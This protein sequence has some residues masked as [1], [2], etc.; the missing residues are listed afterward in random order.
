MANNKP[1]LDEISFFH[2][3][4]IIWFEKLKIFIITIFSIGLAVGFIFYKNESFEVRTSIKPSQQSVFVKFTSLNQILIDNGF[5]NKKKFGYELLDNNTVFK[6]F[7]HEFNDYEEMIEILK[8]DPYVQKSIK[9]LD[10]KFK[11]ETLNLKSKLYPQL[12]NKK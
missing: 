7:I 4:E 5:S 12:L 9:N 8:R 3:F 6:R 10:E 1:E 2:I 11:S